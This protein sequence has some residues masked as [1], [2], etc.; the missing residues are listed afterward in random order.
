MS[1]FFFCSPGGIST[2]VKIS[3][4]AVTLALLLSL[5][6][7]VAAQEL[8][9]NFTGTI[10]FVDPVIAGGP[11]AE[12]QAVSGSFTFDPTVTDEN[13]SPAIGHYT[14]VTQFRIDIPGAGYTATATPNTSR[15]FIDV[16]D[17]AGTDG[18]RYVVDVEPP[19]QVIAPATIAGMPQ[20]W[21]TFLLRDRTGG[22][23]SS[24]ALP[25]V[26]PSLANWE[27]ASLLIGLTA[28]RDNVHLSG[29]AV[30]IQLTS[31]T[32][33]SPTVLLDA[34][35]RS[36]MDLNLRQ[37]QSNRLDGKLD[38][39]MNAVDD[40]N[41][42]DDVAARQSMYAFINT[43]KAEQGKKLTD[44]EAAQL[45]AAANAVIGALEGK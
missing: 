3:A 1:T 35:V 5:P 24:D 26:P 23:L 18:D 25:V 44:A 32:G 7:A 38:L 6:Q 11:F 13:A 30:R 16:R 14:S 4:R 15:G 20:L 31:L 17:N 27:E 36:V 41:A 28:T 45:I 33:P 37:G 2:M 19:E 42:H 22:A 43:V 10:S 34:L 21:F 39:A 12:G 9:F 8:T 29:D 40:K